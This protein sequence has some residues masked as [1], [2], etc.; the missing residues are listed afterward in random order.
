MVDLTR[1]RKKKGEKEMLATFSY[2]PEPRVP[3]SK[4][5]MRDPVVVSTGKKIRAMEGCDSG[6]A[7]GRATARRS[8]SRGGLKCGDFTTKG[9]QIAA[10]MEFF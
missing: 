3:L 10:V 5:L 2:S 9:F 8:G 4:E 7:M 1:K 6:A